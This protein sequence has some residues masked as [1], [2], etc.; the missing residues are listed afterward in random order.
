MQFFTI[1][2]IRQKIFEIP[3]LQ[4]I[5]RFYDRSKFLESILTIL[6]DEIFVR[7][8]NHP[9]P[10]IAET[11]ASEL[12]RNRSRLS[13]SLRPAFHSQHYRAF[14]R[15]QQRRAW[16]ELDDRVGAKFNE[17]G[18]TGYG[19][20]IVFDGFPRGEGCALRRQR[21]DRYQRELSE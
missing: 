11:D 10:W 1:R 20:G 14:R 8:E 19:R 15:S 2:Y 9:W 12:T 4:P 5:Y 13:L 17:T 3:S 7:D 21:A 16:L 6:F 18:L